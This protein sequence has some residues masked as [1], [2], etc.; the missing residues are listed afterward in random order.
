MRY[1]GVFVV[2][3]SAPVLTAYDEHLAVTLATVASVWYVFNI[4]LF[5]YLERRGAARGAIIQE[6]FDMKIFCMPMIAAREPRILP[7]DMVALKMPSRRAMYSI[8]KLRDWYP[9]ETNSPG[10]VAIAIAQ[11][12]NAAYTR[13]LLLWYA[14]L[15]LVVLIVWAFVAVWI[16]LFR[17]FSLATFLLAVVIPILPP[18]VDAWEEFTVVR[19]ASREREALA[20]EIHDAIAVDAVNEILP[21]Q[22]LAWQSQLFSLRRDAPLVPDWLYKLLRN[23]NEREM[24]A[25]ANDMST[26]F[27]G[28]KG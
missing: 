8:E 23:R 27:K 3:V 9:I 10:R 19:L 24:L 4:A 18:L 11:R 1:L 6:E 28:G 2:A 17:D 20:N 12:A 13:R 25:A 16:G 5:K 21:E 26:K 22:L 15:W 14:S 7:E